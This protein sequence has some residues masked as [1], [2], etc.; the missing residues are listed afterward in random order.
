MITM[1]KT[2]SPATKQTAAARYAEAQAEAQDLLKRL[3]TRLAADQQEQASA[4]ADW[5][6]VG[7]LAHVN[8]QLAQ[9]LA[10][11]GDRSAV[12]AKGL[13]Y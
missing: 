12:E 7:S 3:A 4:P 2:K 8:E 13:E 9:V 5:G 1:S 6:Y 10:F 11:L